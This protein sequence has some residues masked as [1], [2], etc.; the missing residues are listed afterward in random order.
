MR[1]P[2]VNDVA[3]EAGVSGKSVSR[4]INGSPHI[5]PGLRRRVEAAVDKLGYVPNSLA[6]NLRVGVADAVG[7]VIDAIADPFFAAVTSTVEAAA[8]DAGLTTVVASTGFD[9][10]RERRQV[11]RMAMQQ[12]RALILAPVPRSHEYLRR[13]ATG[14]P[15]VM[16]D[17]AVEVGG[18]D[19]VRVDDRATARTAVGHLLRGGHRRIAFVGY[20]PGFATLRDRLSGYREALAGQTDAHADDELSRPTPKTDADAV[21]LLTALLALHDPPTAVFAANTRAGSRMAYALHTTGR[22]ELALVSFGDFPLSQALRPPVTCVDHDPRAIGRAAMACVLDRLGGDPGP[23][24]DVLVET[25]LVPRGSGEI[26][27]GERRVTT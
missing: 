23:P 11:Q 6:R 7:V 16:I 26:E 3:A 9:P 21:R 5:S 19:T 20:D 13:Y 10:E 25:V 2:T 12:V 18:Y 17:R 15:V 22:V 8:L 1:R 27:A 4:V 24:R 14:R